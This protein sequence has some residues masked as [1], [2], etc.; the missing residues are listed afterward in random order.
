VTAELASFFEAG[1]GFGGSCLPKDTAAIA[2]LGEEAGA[3]L[4][5]LQAVREVNSQQPERL[6]E[7]A[8][9]AHGDLAG[10]TAGVLGLAFKPDTDDV[11]ESPAF[12]VIRGLL[13]SGARVRVHDPVACAEAS[14]SLEA[15]GVEC[16]SSL[17][18]IA[19]GSDILFLVTR[20]AEYQRLP[21]VLNALEHPPLLVD[22][23]RVIA[24]NSVPRYEGIGLS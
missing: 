2:A 20:W 11:R 23:R 1:C 13:E 12:P 22:G 8:R 14:G 21:Q 9:R 3:R 18:S 4:R 16:E 19:A 5:V 15:L 24:P 7:I 6:V 17:E 10:I